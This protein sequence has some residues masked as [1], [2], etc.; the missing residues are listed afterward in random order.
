MRTGKQCRERWY[1]HL[2]P[3]I[4]KSTW[5][6]SEIQIVFDLQKVYGNHWSRISQHLQGRTD[7]AVKNLYYSSI[8]KSQ[9]NSVK[10]KGRKKANKIVKEKAQTDRK[11]KKFRRELEIAN[12]DEEMTEVLLSLSKARAGKEERAKES[13]SGSFLEQPQ[14]SYQEYFVFPNYFE[15][16]FACADLGLNPWNCQW[17]Y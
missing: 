17:S 13:V 1:N 15:T 5:T 9:R 10:A 6:E 2:S 8:R 12:D 16:N 7:N 14:V 3:S 11:V 4:N